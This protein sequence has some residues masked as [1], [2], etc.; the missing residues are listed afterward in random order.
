MSEQI[1]IRKLVELDNTNYY[2]VSADKGTIVTDDIKV[3]NNLL[4]GTK[5][6]TKIEA[7]TS[8][9]EILVQLFGALKTYLTLQNVDTLSLSN[10]D[11][12]VASTKLL[13]SL[14]DNFNFPVASETKLGGIKVGKNLKMDGDKLTTSFSF[15]DNLS[16]TSTN[17]VQNKVLANIIPDSASSTNKLADIKFVIDSIKAGANYYRGTFATW[18]DVPNEDNYNRYAEDSLHNRKPIAN[19]YMVIENASDYDK[20]NPD[21]YAGAWRFMYVGL[22]S[23]NGKNG[24]IP[25]YRIIESFSADQLA[26]LNSG[27]N[28]TL[29][30]KIRDTDTE[31]SD[32]STNPVEN[33]AVKTELDKK[34]NKL[35][36][37]TVPTA[38]S[39]KIMTSGSIKTALDKKQNTLTF[40][41]APKAKSNNVLSSGVIKTALDKKQNAIVSSNWGADKA[42]VTDANSKL[43]VIEGVSA[44]NVSYLSGVTSNIQTQL[45]SKAPT[46]SPSFTGTPKC[47]TTT[48]TSGTNIV[49]VDYL[50]FR[51][52][53][54]YTNYK[55]LAGLDIPIRWDTETNIVRAAHIHYNSSIWPNYILE[56]CD[57]WTKY[58]YLEICTSNTATCN[59][60]L[61]L[62]NVKYLWQQLN[63]MYNKNGLCRPGTKQSIVFGEGVTG[64]S[65]G[66]VNSAYNE[67]PQRNQSYTFWSKVNQSLM[68]TNS[69]SIRVEN[70]DYANMMGYS[71]FS[72]ILEDSVKN[73][74]TLQFGKGADV[75]IYFHWLWPSTVSIQNCKP[76]F[77]YNYLN[78]QSLFC[79]ADL[80]WIK[81]YM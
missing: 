64:W 81:G 70:P 9:Y 11:D 80:L 21:K 37:D 48:A 26:A 20:V 25:A 55:V 34:Q 2:P 17:P 7:P 50:N 10:T 4:D 39:G 33:R 53:G 28:A 41:D 68:T 30:Q 45:N 60:Q 1:E 31:L 14:L 18:D 63:D 38:G 54:D 3:N 40:D 5:F 62:I 19:D 59:R 78:F 6:K 61:K 23:T 76:L 79:D 8:L 75:G 46:N 24:W 22:W 77:G 15:D 29:R 71:T 13:K 27:I 35:Q 58:Q 44:T 51:I 65:L 36:F 12:T 52:G 49:N 67:N 32:T 56:L 16:K 69:F 42:V 47:P 57:N 73:G 74:T 66:V 72:Y 43:R